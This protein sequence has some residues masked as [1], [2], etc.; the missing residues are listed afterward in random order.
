M[1]N[2]LQIETTLLFAAI[3]GVLHV[4]FTLRVGMYRLHSK[5][6]LGDGDD[7]ELR[8]CIRRINWVSKVTDRPE[9]SCGA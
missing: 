4:V 6:S 9:N 8:K 7:G 3:F 2:L 5:I 1:E